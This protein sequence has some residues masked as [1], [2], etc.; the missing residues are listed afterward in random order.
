MS[1][2]LAFLISKKSYLIGSDSENNRYYSD[3]KK[4]WVMYS[5]SHDNIRCEYVA[6]L[7]YFNDSFPDPDCS[8]S[9]SSVN[10]I[11]LSN[12]ILNNKR[13]SSISK[14]ISDMKKSK[15]SSE[16]GSIFNQREYERWDHDS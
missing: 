16:E 6:W 5:A 10:D 9:D 13:A 1:R 7:H 8:A 3:G 11:S 14:S 4:R 2:W 15:N 12:N